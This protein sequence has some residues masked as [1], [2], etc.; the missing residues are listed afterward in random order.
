MMT[1]LAQKN[2][3]GR[4]W[5]NWNLYLLILTLCKSSDDGK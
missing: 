2:I 1:V 4:K 3:D 5:P